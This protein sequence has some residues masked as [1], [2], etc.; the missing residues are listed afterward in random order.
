MGVTTPEYVPGGASARAGRMRLLH[1]GSLFLASRVF[2]QACWIGAAVVVARTTTPAVFGHYGVAF[3]LVLFLSVVAMLGLENTAVRDV[4]AALAS[5]ETGRAAAVTR[6]VYRLGLRGVGITSLLFLVVGPVFLDRLLNAH[7]LV[8][9]IGWLVAWNAAVA[10]NQMQAAMMRGAHRLGI[11]S[12]LD[13]SLRA[14]LTL[15]GFVILA[16]A[17]RP[18][19]T[20]LLVVSTAA[21]ATSAGIG[22]L[23]LGSWRRS[24]GPVVDTEVLPL[25][26]AAWPVMASTI[27]GFG[28][29]H[30]DIWLASALLSDGELARYT[31]AARLSF[32]TTMP[33]VAL[34]AAIAPATAE[35]YRLGK[36]AELEQLARRAA[37]A[38]S[39]VALLVLVVF[40]A[41]GDQLLAS[42]YGSFYANG[43]FVL[44]ALT[45]GRLL[46]A[47]TGPCGMLLMMSGRQRVQLMV[48][49]ATAL[50]LLV[51]IIAA[52]GGVGAAGIALLY[53]A[54]IG[55]SNVAMMIVARRQLGIATQ[56][57]PSR[58]S[59]LGIVR[60]LRSV[61][62]PAR[63]DPAPK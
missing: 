21:A 1:G 48:V 55:G 22:A 45:F 19:L 56:A 57:D 44:V 12:L 18:T 28:L 40:V 37:T 14:G 6:A 20:S 11:A 34:T 7:A 62:R 16:A 8:P 49:T 63:P 5:N 50:L 47:W 31:A 52:G 2:A 27:V 36:T 23:A 32:L 3:S 42:L 13:G 58:E 24:L 9:V 61:I 17:T 39:A 35:L 59:V 38:S 4:S 15:I 26:Q 43:V 10:L 25:W 60:S 54:V 53:S 46:L 33:M 30:A 29:Q 51:V 41:F